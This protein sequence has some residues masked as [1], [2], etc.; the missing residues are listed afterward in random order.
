VIGIEEE[1]KK[2]DQKKKKDGI[3]MILQPA[4]TL[5]YIIDCLN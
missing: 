2:H 1:K 3:Y 4:K 5:I